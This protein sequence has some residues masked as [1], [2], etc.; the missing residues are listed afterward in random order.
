[1]LAFRIKEG[2]VFLPSVSVA[3]I[4]M[5]GGV[6]SGLLLLGPHIVPKGLLRHSRGTITFPV[7][8]E[9]HLPPHGPPL[10]TLKSS[11]HA[12]AIPQTKSVV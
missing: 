9:S 2:E 5:R 4:V 11:P 8:A 10:A 1:M 6:C 3:L 7:K 12:F